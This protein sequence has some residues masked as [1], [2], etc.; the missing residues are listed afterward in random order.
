M[1]IT[2]VNNKNCNNKGFNYARI[3]KNCPTIVEVC[4]TEAKILEL[5]NNCIIFG[6]NMLVERE[7]N[8]SQYLGTPD[9][10]KMVEQFGHLFGPVHI[11]PGEK[12]SGSR[13]TDLEFIRWRA[14]VYG[15]I[16]QEIKERTRAEA[17][18]KAPQVATT[19]PDLTKATNTTGKR[20]CYD[21]CPDKARYSK[22]QKKLWS[23]CSKDCAACEG[24][25]HVCAHS[26]CK[27]FLKQHQIVANEAQ[28]E[29]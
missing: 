26:K 15:A 9:D 21:N 4:E 19:S 11:G 25:V 27:E 13:V 14:S 23:K 24:R 16:G 2:R 12:S 3:L 7:H 29:K 6:N 17:K 28:K 10:E 5:V 8:P 22:D 1:Y 20:C 18:N